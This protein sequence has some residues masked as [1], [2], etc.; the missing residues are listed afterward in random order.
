[1]IY[2][3]PGLI[4]LI[5]EMMVQAVAARESRDIVR[6]IQVL[7]MIASTPAPICTVI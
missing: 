2:D 4:G 5:L 3:P 6:N 1:M 7:D